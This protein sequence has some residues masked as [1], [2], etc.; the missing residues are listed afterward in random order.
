MQ[1][2]PKHFLPHTSVSLQMNKKAMEHHTKTKATDTRKQE[3]FFHSLRK[4]CNLKSEITTAAY[5]GLL[6]KMLSPHK[7]S[8][9]LE[10][11]SN[12]ICN[13]FYVMFCSSTHVSSSMHVRE[14]RN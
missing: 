2:L 1:A 4:K 7:V 8:E 6:N 12:G 11:T 3:D 13:S 9:F 14:T 5:S 10:Y